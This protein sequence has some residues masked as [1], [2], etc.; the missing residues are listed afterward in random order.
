MAK[1]CLKVAALIRNCPRAAS[2][3]LLSL[4]VAD[5]TAVSVYTAAILAVRSATAGEAVPLGGTTHME[6][7]PVPAWS[8]PLPAKACN[9]N[10]IEKAGADLIVDVSPFRLSKTPAVNARALPCWKR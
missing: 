10:A 8:V 4:V 1:R 9:A 6:L 2:E 3:E 5:F 7:D